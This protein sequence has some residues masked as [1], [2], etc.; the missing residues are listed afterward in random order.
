VILLVLVIK[1]NED[2]A[3]SSVGGEQDKHYEIRDEQRHV[4]G[5]G[6]IKAFKSRIEEML[7]NVL[8]NTARRGKS[9]Q[10]R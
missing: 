4:K 9:G 7:A 1:I 6:M 8:S 10:E 3:V 5:V 2:I